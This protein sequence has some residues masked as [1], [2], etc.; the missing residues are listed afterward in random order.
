MPKLPN[1]VQRFFSRFGHV[2]H[3]AVNALLPFVEKGF[4]TFVVGALP[5]AENLVLGIIQNKG[6]ISSADRDAAAAQI[7]TIAVASAQATGVQVT[8]GISK[9]LLDTAYQGL[10]FQGKIIPSDNTQNVGISPSAVDPSKA[11]TGPP[12]P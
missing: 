10:K 4:G 11:V 9:W 7:K 1:I 5:V 3:E 8:E 12:K 6:T 2:E